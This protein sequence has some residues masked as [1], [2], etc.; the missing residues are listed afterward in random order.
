[1]AKRPRSSKLPKI[2]FFSS[3]RF[4]FAFTMALFSGLLM[5]SVIFLLEQNF[6]ESLVRA[7]IGKG[8]G[9]AQG[10]AFNAEDPLLTGDDLYL[11]SAINNATRSPDI[12]YAMIVDN[13]LKIRA[14]SDVSRVGGIYQLPAQTELIESQ[15]DF[16]VKRVGR[17]ADALFDLQVPI[18]TLAD[19]PLRLGTVHIG[20]S[21]ELV[22]QEI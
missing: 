3:L 15:K 7:S 18:F 9:I 22:N 14:S 19:T 4:K 6:R 17:D 5:L 21:D 10:V 1:M 12:R 11:F 8:I 2:G 20:L 16:Q 13:E